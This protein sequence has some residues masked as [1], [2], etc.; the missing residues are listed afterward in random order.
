MIWLRTVFRTAFY[1]PLLAST[2]AVSIF[3]GYLFDYQFGVVNYYLGLVG[4][5]ECRG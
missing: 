5:P 2:A 1:L 4:M 3:M